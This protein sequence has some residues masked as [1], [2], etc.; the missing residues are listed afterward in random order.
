MSDIDVGVLNVI[1]DSFA[2]DIYIFLPMCLLQVII[3]MLML[4]QIR[5]Y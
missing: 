4:A 2:D 1:V 5:C 3:L